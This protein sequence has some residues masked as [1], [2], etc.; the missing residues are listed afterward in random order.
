MIR[1]SSNAK[2]FPLVDDLSLISLMIY[3]FALLD[4]NAS[5]NANF[6]ISE[7]YIISGCYIALSSITQRQ[8]DK[9]THQQSICTWIVWEGKV[10][11]VE[12]ASSFESCQ[13][14]RFRIY[15]QS[16]RSH[17]IHSRII[18]YFLKFCYWNVRAAWSIKNVCL[19][20]CGEK[21]YSW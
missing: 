11:E 20:L 19:F 9:R 7:F 5:I 4:A 8:T 16:F 14:I 6:I 18:W 10:Q 13:E 1:L 3:F 21:L 15:F 2:S 12:I 17:I